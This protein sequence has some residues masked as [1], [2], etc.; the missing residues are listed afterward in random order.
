M[1]IYCKREK[2]SELQLDGAD[3]SDSEKLRFNYS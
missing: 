3:S 2:D 1:K